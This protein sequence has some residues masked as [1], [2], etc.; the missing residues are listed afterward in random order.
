MRFPSQILEQWLDKLNDPHLEFREVWRLFDDEPRRFY[1]RFR[2]PL[3]DRFHYSPI[4]L[5]LRTEKAKTVGRYRESDLTGES[6]FF[7]KGLS[8][9]P[10]EDYEPLQRRPFPLQFGVGPRILDR[11]LGIKFSD[12]KD[13]ALLWGSQFANRTFVEYAN[14]LE[15]TV[16]SKKKE[17]I[18]HSNPLLA[19]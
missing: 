4:G 18:T 12:P 7:F 10:Y 17:V 11:Y 6:A 9:T 2:N 16:G 3:D 5:L 1:L 13:A 14:W 19:F 8:Y 15:V